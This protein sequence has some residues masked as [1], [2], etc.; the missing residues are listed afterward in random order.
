MNQVGI[1][2]A[3]LVGTGI[4][5]GMAAKE[6]TEKGLKTLVWEHGRMVKHIKVHLT[7]RDDSWDLPLKGELSK[8]DKRKMDFQGRINWDPKEIVNFFLLT[9]VRVM[10]YLPVFTNSSL[11][12]VISNC[13]SANHD[14]N[15]LKGGKFS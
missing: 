4:S 5:G 10:S 6:L 2:D 7:K 11:I 13:S 9:F 12:R 14:A 3:I 15:Q 8:V 1:F